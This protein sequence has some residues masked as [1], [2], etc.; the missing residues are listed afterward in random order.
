[1]NRRNILSLFVIVAFGLDLLPGNATAQ[2]K[3]LKDQLVGTWSLVS[4]ERIA[5]DGRKVLSYGANPQGINFFGADGRFFI[6]WARADLPKLA[7]TDRSKATAEEAKALMAGVLSYYGTYTLDELSKTITFRIE[8]TNFPNQLGQQQ[9][10]VISSLTADEL[11][12]S[13]P[14][15]TAGGQIQIAMKRAK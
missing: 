13:N 3:S 6:M 5:P 8:V 12:Y 7:S 10:R 4:W 1:M 11:K 15:S 9:K 14:V 2:Q